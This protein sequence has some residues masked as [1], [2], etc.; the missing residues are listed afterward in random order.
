MA[1]TPEEIAQKYLLPGG[2][3]TPEEIAQKYLVGPEAGKSEEGIPPLSTAAEPASGPLERQRIFEEA[4]PPP[5]PLGEAFRR[6]IEREKDRPFVPGEALQE[7]IKPWLPG[8]HIGFGVIG[9]LGKY[10][11]KPYR[12]LY[13]ATY[14]HQTERKIPVVGGIGKMFRPKS[15]PEFWENL[16]KGWD[17]EPGDPHYHSPLD[18]MGAVLT[19]RRRYEAREQRILT[20]SKGDKFAH[21]FME[22]TSELVADALIDTVLF[23]MGM[24]TATKFAKMTKR[25]RMQQ[26]LF[27]MKPRSN[28][29]EFIPFKGRVVK[30]KGVHPDVMYRITFN[31][32]VLVSKKDVVNGF[33]DYILAQMRKVQ[34]KPDL[35]MDDLLRF[36]VFRNQAPD[37]PVWAIPGARIGA[38][39]KPIYKQRWA[40]PTKATQDVME[41]TQKEI[42]EL[43]ANISELS[44][45]HNQNL[46]LLDQM[47][48]SDLP[49]DP[50]SG[51]ALQT[52][53]DFTGKQLSQQSGKLRKAQSKL[54]AMQTGGYDTF[55][56]SRAVRTK[57][58]DDFF[59]VATDTPQVK[60]DINKV[61]DDI[62]LGKYTKKPTKE[63]IK[64]GEKQ[65]LKRSE[66]IDN[67]DLLSNDD[68]A[69]VVEAV[70]YLRRDPHSFSM[71][72]G[73]LQWLKDI[74]GESHFTPSWMWFTRNGSERIWQVQNQAR[75]AMKRHMNKDIDGWYDVLTPLGKPK[76]VIKNDDLQRQI[77]L[78]AD[79]Q[80]DRFWADVAGLSPERI[81]D[82]QRAGQYIN[83]AADP[84]LL[85][86][87]RQGKLSLKGEFG[88]PYAQEHYITHIFKNEIRDA[89]AD[90]K[91]QRLAEAF[92]HQTNTKVPINEFKMRWGE[93]GYL[94]NAHAAFMAMENHQ[95]FNL[96]MEPALKEAEVLAR[97]SGDDDL[98]K[99]VQTW[100]N[101]DIRGIP[102]KYELA[103]T[104]VAKWPARGLETISKTAEK[105]FGL[106][107]VPF[108]DA[109][110][111]RTKDRA[112]RQLSNIWRRAVYFK[113]MGFNT[114]PM[115]RNATQGFM[116]TAL[117]DVPSAWWG[118][119]SLFTDGGHDLLKHS[120]L[121]I[122]R[123][124]LESFDARN[125]SKIEKL[126]HS[127]FRWV[128]KWPN[129]S[130]TFNTSLYYEV[131]KNPK[132]VE[133]VRKY[134]QF[135]NPAKDVD[136]FARAMSRAADAGEL[137]NAIA[138][139][140][141][142]TRLSQ[143]S[144]VDMPQ[145]LWGPLGKLGGQYTSWAQNYFYS[146]LP[147][148]TKWAVTGK[149]STGQILTKTER[150][151]AL[152]HG[153]E[154]WML[155]AGARAMGLDM[156]RLWMP[157]PSAEISP[158]I[159]FGEG[160][161]MTTFGDTDRDKAEGWR[162]MWKTIPVGVPTGVKRPF[163][164]LTGEM[165]LQY[166]FGRPV[167]EE[168]PIAPYLPGISKPGY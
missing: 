130:R 164:V 24:K 49:S 12:A 116:G 127:G 29:G 72:G 132:L 46:S 120:D 23:G 9:T 102:T 123:M 31:R 156:T 103:A 125:L 47:R 22:F 134:G 79:R 133:V 119:K 34:M 131:R 128:D 148:I 163:K 73:K 19:G 144:Y 56:L 92:Q 4:G 8:F 27:R 106:V 68:F 165:P 118:A 36:H 66:L 122:D 113:T 30:L 155:I 78:W 82:I 81:E 41:A 98:I 159:E 65:F 112:F 142:K 80:E 107:H 57:Y 64:R 124:P 146:Y 48:M 75:I 71:A 121:L 115:V 6:E 28:I 2:P 141:F 25:P 136:R 150:M 3:P 52:S 135:D 94:E 109:L 114:A 69:S 40:M 38:E 17:A 139:A 63:G 10:I 126:G 157:L 143:Y 145:S 147:E 32:Q 87:V 96:Y 74:S 154:V 158:A 117:S 26:A 18:I 11:D 167:E 16:R 168:K 166:L 58:I 43:S 129:V 84:F 76:S 108:P 162:K 111:F 99:Y 37:M 100:I 14:Q 15:Y 93:E 33:D 105:G 104:K 90:W 39:P 89:D 21:S 59:D 45:R 50:A 88:L 91:L 44:V 70:K 138:I 53:V 160:F 97:M 5:R 1:Q 95:S 151:A 13:N 149:M 161:I 77:F 86:A 62:T 51:A 61:I 35:T 140:N 110:S 42:A 85:E 54:A 55:A 83:D 101:T 137:Q 20:G 152:R 153:A 60:V 67:L 7:E